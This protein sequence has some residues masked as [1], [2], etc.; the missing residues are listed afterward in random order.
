M[1]RRAG[2]AASG[3]VAAALAIPSVAAAHGIVGRADLPIPGWLFGWAA[4][5]VLVV[6]FVALALLWPEPRLEHVRQRRVIALPALADVVLGVAGIAV[7]VA[8]VYA[9]L[10]GTQT[11]AANL[12]PRLVFVAFWVGVPVASVVF[13]DVFRLLSPWRAAARAVAWA[14][15][16]LGLRGPAALPYPARLG[17]WPAAAGIFAFAWVELVYT[18]RDDPSTLAVLA[19]AYA[20]IQFVGMSVYGIEAWSRNADAFGVYFS[21]FARLSAWVRRDGALWLRVPLSGTTSLPTPPGVVALLAV[22]IGST[23]F[24][25]A[26]EGQL[27]TE[28]G[29]KLQQLFV[30]LGF[31]LQAGLEIAFTIGLAGAI[32]VIAGIYHLGVRGMHGVR[33]ALSTRELSRQFVHTLIPIA[34]AYVLAHYFSFLAYEGQAFAFLISDPLGDGSNLFGTAGQ[35]IDYSLFSATAIWY[36]QVIVLVTGHVSGLMLAHDR[37]LTVYRSPREATRS[38][39]WMLVVMV[40]FTSLGLW[41]LSVSNQ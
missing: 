7:F 16:R 24:D 3:A 8:G 27:W 1:I 17:W 34:F 31:S 38:Q 11:A 13:G 4:A 2:L 20:A 18:G 19:L 5:V 32:L 15:G 41:L 36:I 12:M 30:D 40:G 26:A 33:P 21:L 10:A 9:G 35:T 23:A 6:S 28:A 14:A 29:P 25:G 37:A 22:S 39:Y